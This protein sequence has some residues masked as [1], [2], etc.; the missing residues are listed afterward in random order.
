MEGRRSWYIDVEEQAK[1]S[2]LE[3]L[4]E[5][6]LG[7]DIELPVDTITAFNRFSGRI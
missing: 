3:Y 5:E 7:R 1:E 2:E 6:I 4:K